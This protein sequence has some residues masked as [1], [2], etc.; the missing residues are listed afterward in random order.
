[1][2]KSPVRPNEQ[3]PQ[4]R[5]LLRQRRALGRWTARLGGAAIVLA[6]PL[7]LLRLDEAGLTAATLAAAPPAPAGAL[8]LGLLVRRW[9]A[10]RAVQIEAMVKSEELIPD[11]VMRDAF[12]VMGW[13]PPITATPVR[14][15]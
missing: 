6:V 13:L 11:P 3:V 4:R 5:E 8:G 12:E 9:R 2:I 10:T 15:P 1:M 14:P 7:A